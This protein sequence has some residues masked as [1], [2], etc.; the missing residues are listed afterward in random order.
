MKSFGRYLHHTPAEAMVSP[1]AAQKGIKRAWNLAC[2][3]EGINPRKPNRLPLLFAI[4]DVLKIPDGFT[5]KLN[6]DASRGEYCA[7]SIGC[8]GGC[9]SGC[10]ECSG[11]SSCSGGCGGGGD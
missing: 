10:G 3:L 11:D 9:G 7:S 5:Y 4:D 1:T 6:C 8:G 2:K